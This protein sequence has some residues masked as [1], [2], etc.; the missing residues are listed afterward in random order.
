MIKET[1]KLVFSAKNGDIDAFGRLAE[2]FY[3]TLTAIAFAHTKSHH[4]AEDAAQETL[5]RAIVSLKKLKNPKKFAPWLSQICRNVSRDIITKQSPELTSQDT[6]EAPK[7]GENPDND[8]KY[9]IVRKAIANLPDTDRE[10]IILRFYNALSY[11]QISEHLGISKGAIN[12]RIKRAKQKI[13]DHL[14][15]NNYPEI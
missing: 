15:H 3:P 14:Q 1:E 12:G 4:S 7:T 2:Q 6:I 8:Q 13:A 5:K 10:I 11:E 9:Q